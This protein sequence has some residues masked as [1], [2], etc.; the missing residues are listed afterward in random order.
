MTPERELLSRV[1]PRLDLIDDHDLCW[2][3]DALLAQP[4]TQRSEAQVVGRVW[5]CAV[6]GEGDA[7]VKAVLNSCGRELPDNTPLYAAPLS[8]TATPSP[9]E[10]PQPE[11]AAT[12]SG[13]A[14]AEKC[15]EICDNVWEQD[16]GTSGAGSSAACALAIRAY[17][18]TLP[19]APKE[20]T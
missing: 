8:E 4:A 14:V 11:S 3:I 7:P 1:R 6:W 20:K 5:R 15:A 16:E 17:A 2:E 18:A 12:A 19:S 9:A 10:K 13:R